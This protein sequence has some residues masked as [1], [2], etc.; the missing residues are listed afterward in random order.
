M[1]FARSCD[2]RIR[3]IGETIGSTL[4]IGLEHLMSTWKPIERAAASSLPR[5]SG[6]ASSREH[7]R[8]LLAGALALS[9]PGCTMPNP[10]FGEVSATDVATSEASASDSGGGTSGGTSA[11]VT[12]DA[13][14]GTQ[15]ATGAST[16]LDSTG[17]V[18]TTGGVCL[19]LDEDGVTDCEGDCDDEDPDTLPGRPEICG[20]NVDNNCNDEIDDEGVCMGYGTFVSQITGDD[21]GMGTQDDPVKTIGKAVD[22]AT[23]IIGTPIEVYVAEGSYSEAIGLVEGVSLIG[24]FQCADDCTWEHDPELY[25]SKIQATTSHGVIAGPDVTAA[26]ELSGFEIYGLAGPPEDDD[27]RA[28]I[29]I[30]RGTPSINDNTIFGPGLDSCMQCYTA[31]IRIFGPSNVDGGAEIVGNYIESGDAAQGF[32]SGT[33]AIATARGDSPAP[34]VYISRNTLVGGTGYW[35]RTLRIEGA[36]GT[37]IKRN[38]VYAG[39]LSAQGATSF[40]AYLHGDLEIDANHFNTDPELTGYCENPSEFGCG[41]LEVDGVNGSITNNV[42]VGMPSAISI[43]LRISSGEDPGF[44]DDLLVANNTI[45]GGGSADAQYSA[46]IRCG[47][48]QG[49]DSLFGRI[50]NNIILGGQA[51]ER[52]GVVEDNKPN[53]T[54]KPNDF[55][56]NLL[57]DYT[58]MYLSWDGNSSLQ[59]D[60]PG[61]LNAEGFANN[62]IA[63]DP[64]LDGSHH[65]S[66]DSPCIDAG[67]DF[68]APGHDMDSEARPKG[69]G[70]DI[71]ADEF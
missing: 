64:A 58:K 55:D 11:G 30:D 23:T 47:T 41:G 53:T 34:V 14:T 49:N 68:E 10:A 40:A 51:G 17:P 26:T 33:H 18:M 43:G 35:A 57:F 56:N 66:G 15:G 50:R 71:G 24:G 27:G 62:N 39:S 60:T 7:A 52:F 59:H 67:T 1:L 13:G 70:F 4:L 25:K 6:A 22:I 61:Q 20:D 44:G 69:D 32:F 12:G 54:C 38:H 31:G 2:L 36:P 21:A 16:G 65:L 5:G 28:A 3:T 8:L 37:T 9:L 42:I 45:D 29:T 46:G 48:L 63:G 19:D